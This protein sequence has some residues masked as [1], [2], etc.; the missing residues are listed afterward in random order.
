MLDL[1][2]A[3][4]RGMGAM[5]ENKSGDVGHGGRGRGKVCTFHEMHAVRQPLKVD[6]GWGREKAREVVDAEAK[7]R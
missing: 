5:R 6:M 4:V 1:V 3:R 7:V 2:F